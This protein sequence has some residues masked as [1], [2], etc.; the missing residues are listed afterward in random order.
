MRTFLILILTAIFVLPCF[1]IEK[2]TKEKSAKNGGAVKAKYLTRY[3]H[4]G[5]VTEAN[6]DK[7]VA[8][9]LE[10]LRTEKFELPDDEHTQ[11]SI[12]TERWCVTAQVSGR[13]TLG[14]YD[15]L[16]ENHPNPRPDTYMRDIP[17]SK[18][19]EIW[20]AVLLNDT[21]KLLSYKWAPLG[22]L[23]KF[24]TNYYRKGK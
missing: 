8:D 11:V 19:K 5:E 20:R 24:K 12:S 9:L 16:D 1:G 21:E 3:G 4:E 2:D 14:N 13:I 22:Q 17:D 6:F 18:L 10:D 23:P 15:I 7:V